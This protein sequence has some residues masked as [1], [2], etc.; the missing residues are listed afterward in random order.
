M[1]LALVS[2]LSYYGAGTRYAETLRAISR[3]QLAAEFD[4]IV[5]GS[6]ETDM[7][8][9]DGAAGAAD[10]AAAGAGAWDAAIRRFCEDFTAKA[11][12]GQIDPVFGREDRKGTRLN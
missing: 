9:A 4:S 2:R 8:I 11:R 1:L 10:S 12:A 7:R 3:E 6:S 5:D